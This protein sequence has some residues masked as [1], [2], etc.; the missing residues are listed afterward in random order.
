MN[1]LPVSPVL[2]G[3]CT[4]SQ[5]GRPA[6]PGRPEDGPKNAPGGRPR[7]WRPRR[8][9]RGELSRPPP[10]TNAAADQA[11]AVPAAPGEAVAVATQLA[12]GL[13]TASLDSPELEGW[14][15]EALTPHDA[16]GLGNFMAGLHVVA[17]QLLHELY[18]ATGEQ[19]E[20]TLRRLAILAEHWR[21][22]LSAG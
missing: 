22:T 14:A 6:G 1:N 15:V 7:R 11:A 2:P 17:Q 18:E 4:D 8:R 5:D 21:G 16:D 13:L 20:D 3:M 9:R 19:P 10:G 12:I